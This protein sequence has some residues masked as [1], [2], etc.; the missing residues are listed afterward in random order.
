MKRKI[1]N[2]K[3]RVFFIILRPNKKNVWL[4]KIGRVGRGF[5]Y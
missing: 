5:F 1:D 4:K 2:G 3:G